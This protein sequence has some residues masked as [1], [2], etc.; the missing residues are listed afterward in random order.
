MLAGAFAGFACGTKPTAVPMLLLAVPL[1]LYLPFLFRERVAGKA[2]AGFIL[3]GLVTFSP[4]P[5]RNLV[6]TGNPVFPEATSVF[7]RAHFSEAQSQRWANAHSP[8][9]GDR[10]TP[11]WKQVVGDWRYGFVFVPLALVAAVLGRQRTSRVLIAILI[12][13]FL[14]WIGFTHVQGRFLVLAIPI[15][16]MLIGQVELPHWNKL[17]S[18]AAI[19]IASVGWIVAGP[20]VMAT[21]PALACATS[22]R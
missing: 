17:V 6:W 7:G 21:A 13:Q 16:A 4:W 8:R 14:F 20:R 22:R 2:V 11:P 15:A 9:P 19:V 3:A 10:L 12:V 18:V 5:I 1:A